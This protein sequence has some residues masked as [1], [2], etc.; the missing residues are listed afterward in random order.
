MNR[1]SDFYLRLLLLMILFSVALYVFAHVSH[2]HDTQILACGGYDKAVKLKEETLPN[3]L[4]V[5]RYDTNGDGQP[6]VNTY[7]SITGQDTHQ[8]YPTFYMLD[9]N[10]DGYPDLVLVDT[11]GEGL[12]DS[13][14]LYVDLNKTTHPPMGQGK[15]DI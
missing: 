8:A 9:T 6:D 12:C 15:R 5:E 1:K 4:I 3:G 2:A 13:I 11:T 7:S 14:K 10:Y